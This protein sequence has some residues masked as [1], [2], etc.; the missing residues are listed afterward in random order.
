LTKIAEMD[1]GREVAR[2]REWVT[3][4]LTSSVDVGR[5]VVVE[6]ARLWF[7][8]CFERLLGEPGAI[9]R[10][11]APEEVDW[12]SG[13]PYAWRAGVIAGNSDFDEWIETYSEQS[14]TVLLE[15]LNDL[16]GVASLEIIRNNERGRPG[17]PTV[18][19]SAI[20]DGDWVRL[21]ARVA[22]EV[23]SSAAG[24]DSIL[25]SMREVADLVNPSAGSLYVPE[26]VL[27][28]PLEAAL[29]RWGGVRES[30]AFLRDYG[31]LTVLAEESGK[32]LGGVEALRASGAFVQ[33]DRLA[34]G[35]YWLLA[36]PTWDEYGWPQAERLFE[37][38]AP[39]LPPG[40][41]SVPTEK[42]EVMGRPPV[43]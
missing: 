2:P 28:T 34:S 3:A 38:F 12:D 15:R 6:A 33:V 20:V 30:R 27:Q 17:T 21:S 37:V 25:E 10:S 9:A 14:R 1:G 22:D 23:V 13:V 26:G 42:L 35:G 32:R 7:R 39:V 4:E 16:P 40:R 29:H 19:I 24:Q 41:P 5:D 18:S 43:P 31:W 11:A 36:T 8:L